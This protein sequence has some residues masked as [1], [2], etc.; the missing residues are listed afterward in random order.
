MSSQGEGSQGPGVGLVGRVR[1]RG[2]WWDALFLLGALAAGIVRFLILRRG[3]APPTIDAGNWLA[4]ADSMLGD[5]VRSPT[6]V[7]PPLVPLLTKA[8]VTM[9]GLTNGVAL[10]AAISSL[11][12]AAG[13]YIALRYAGLTWEGLAPALLV[14]GASSVGETTAWGGFPQLIALGLTPIALVLFDR[15]LRTWSL[16]HALASG[17]T[18]MA[19]LATSHMVSAAVSLAAGA[20][21]V[22][23]LI[24]PPS[25]APHGRR[26][27]S[28]LA[29]VL[30]PSI[31]LAPLYWTLARAFGGGSLTAVS[32]NQL[33]W[34]NLLERIEFLYRDTRWMWRLLLPLALLAPVILWWR[35]RT[36]LW[37]VISA[38]LAATIV[39][40]AV[41][42]EERFFY[43]LTPITALGLA[44]WTAWAAELYGIGSTATAGALRLARAAAAMGVALLVTAVTL[45]FVRGA[46]FFE[47][48]R[49]YYGILTPGLVE[50]IRYLGE[51]SD[52]NDVVAVTSLNNA[53]LGWWVEAIARR[54]TI[55][56]SPLHWLN[57]E[58]ETRRAS[59]GNGLFVPPFPT[60]D[61][62]QAAEAAGIELI[63][64]PTSWTFYDDAAI[65]ALA[66]AAP[67]AVL[68][69]NG[70]AVV[71]RPEA[72]DSQ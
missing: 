13:V 53:P 29:L 71:I 1:R 55:Y 28:R 62:L 46:E 44:L 36:P 30:L 52:R 51:F 31:W 58:D 64:L 25:P 23:A 63:L 38:V 34:T 67:D 72:V 6:I 39:L 49:D 43:L 32:P 65:E 50:G 56:G 35:H 61:K 33:T 22:A 60:Y 70:D 21:L 40:V 11:M 41:T 15:F 59:V 5:G 27:L 57:F 3:G 26:Q 18:V 4:F 42:R 17:L 37:R 69:L 8:S 66:E 2:I 19:V 9:F 20:M 45:Q 48:Q 54:Q 7:Y 47:Q 16:R 68:R 24:W 10:L 14:A 12:P